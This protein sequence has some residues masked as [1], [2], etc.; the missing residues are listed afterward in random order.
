[1]ALLRN[2]GLLRDF[3]AVARTGSLSA[4]AEELAVSQ[5][6]LTKSVRRLEHHYGVTLFERR[7]RGMA[8][9]AFG[10]TLLGHA[11]LIDSQC[12]FAD[13]EMTAFAQGHTGRFRIG[14]GPFWGATIMPLAI[15]R[16]QEQLPSLEV[17]LDV[18]VNTV[19]HPRLFGGDLDIVVCAL[20]EAEMLPPGIEVRRFFDLHMRVIA[21]ERHPLLKRRRVEAAD[22]AKYPWALYQRDRE[23]VRKLVAA[24]GRDGG[25][26]PRIVVES[27]SVLAVMELLKAGPYLSCIAD[28]FLRARPDSGIGVVPYQ[29][30]IWTCPSGALFHKSLRDFAPV[31]MLLRA[32]DELSARLSR[33]VALPR[34]RHAA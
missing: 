18:G 3:L 13:V 20:S 19:I 26:P 1:M 8:L 32:I 15:A 6:A 28:A 16:L 22:F 31:R 23:I 29:R 25:A 27:S 9:T 21:G 10:E 5:P 2:A 12:R 17:E 24:L 14:A 7:A 33:P 30:D 4:A 34:K 11:K